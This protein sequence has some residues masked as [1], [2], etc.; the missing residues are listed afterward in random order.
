MRILNPRIASCFLFILCTISYGQLDAGKEAQIDQL[1]QSWN[2]PNHP[3]GAIA[4]MQGDKVVYSKAYGLASMEYLVPNSTGT[5]F[6]VASVSKQFSALGIVLLQE[7]GKLSVDDTIDKYID[8]LAPFGSKITIRQMLHHTSGL[9]SLHALFALAG[10]RNDDSRTNADL[11]RIMALQTELNFE[12]GSEYMYCNTGY[13]FLANIIEKVTE[14]SF[15]DFMK[16]DVFIPLGMHE[17]YV[18]ERYDRIV[19]NNA[20][21]YYTQ[22]NGFIRAVE[23]W[24]YIGSGNM[25]TSTTDLLRYLKNYYDPLPGWENIFQTMQTLD[26]LNDGSYLEYAFGVNV[27]RLY[28]KKRITHG[29]SIGGF[30]SNV[31]VFPEEKTSV[32]IITNFSSSGPAGKSNEIAGILFGK[33]APYKNLKVAKIPKSTMQ[34]YAGDYWDDETYQE[35]QINISGDTLFLG[36]SY[37]PFLP[38]ANGHFEALDSE[39]GTKLEFEEGQFIYMPGSNKPRVFEKVKEEP[40]TDALAEAYVGPYYSPEI[41]TSY[42]IFYKEGKLYA[43]HIRFGELP[44]KQKFKDLLQGEYP[45]STLKFKR[46]DGKITGVWISDGRV[47]N[48]WFEKTE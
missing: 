1:F 2:Q 40:L 33:P 29:G 31:A 39:N 9:R 18:E 14:K 5:L 28:G 24:G 23:Y 16:E 17:T 19:P 48:L 27:D 47:R 8:G 25:H 38:V 20:T 32:A 41:H 12:P 36:R 26:P 46:E 10:W 22:R 37:T 11:D 44:L 35:Q 43:F 6:N 45:L 30:R 34:S 15:V 3:G 7:Q 13:M 21:S 42:S 4:I